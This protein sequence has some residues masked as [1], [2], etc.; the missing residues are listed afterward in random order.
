MRTE[1]SVTWACAAL[2]S[3]SVAHAA[4]AVVRILFIEV[5]CNVS[6]S[7]SVIKRRGIAVE[8]RGCRRDYKTCVRLGTELIDAV[9]AE[10]M[11]LRSDKLQMPYDSFAESDTL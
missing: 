7:E 8:C 4:I 2:A 1:F 3:I 11:C 6:D 10:L 9:I 5:S